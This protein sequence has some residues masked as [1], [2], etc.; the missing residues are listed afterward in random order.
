MNVVIFIYFF[1][2]LDR[3]SERDVSSTDLNNTRGGGG[4]RGG[5]TG[6]PLA[7]SGHGDG[8]K[9]MGIPDATRILLSVGGGGG[10]K[11]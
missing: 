4:G 11:G 6:R 3:F 7:S 10:G 9:G 1:K 8:S 5:K 2:L